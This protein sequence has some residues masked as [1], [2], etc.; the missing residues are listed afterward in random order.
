MK[1][2]SILINTSR[3]AI[4]NTEDLQKALEN[5]KIAGAALD[6]TFPEPLAPSHPFIVCL[7]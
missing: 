2:N 4:V 1:K 7:M 5:K 3:G 6:T